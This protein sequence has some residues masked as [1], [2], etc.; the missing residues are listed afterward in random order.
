MR[1][2]ELEGAFT[3]P[4]V[5]G[6]AAKENSRD[7]TTRKQKIPRA[8]LSMPCNPSL[9]HVSRPMPGGVCWPGLLISH[10]LDQIGCRTRCMLSKQE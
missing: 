7:Q 4:P 9:I 5:L 1:S 8:P 10:T 6:P 3:C 2:V